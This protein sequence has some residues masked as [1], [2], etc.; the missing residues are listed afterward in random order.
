M[1]Y[2]LHFERTSFEN[3]YKVTATPVDSDKVVAA[4]ISALNWKIA[5]RRVMEELKEIKNTPIDKIVE[6]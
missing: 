1:Q 6:I 3:A 4:G 2:R 5:E